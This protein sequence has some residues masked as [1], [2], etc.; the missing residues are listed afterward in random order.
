MQPKTF[1]HEE[2]CSS[3]YS[4]HPSHWITLLTASGREWVRASRQMWRPPPST[5]SCWKRVTR[6][7]RLSRTLE[8]WIADCG[9]CWVGNRCLWVIGEGF[10]GARGR[11]GLHHYVITSLRNTNK[12]HKLTPPPGTAQMHRGHTPLRGPSTPP[13]GQPPVS[14]LDRLV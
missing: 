7:P 13:A 5:P 6:A 1:R 14:E 3:R 2:I 9:V 8:S 4:P 10:G 12:H 11:G